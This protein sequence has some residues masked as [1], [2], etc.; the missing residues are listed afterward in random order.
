MVGILFWNVLPDSTPP[1]NSAP[2]VSLPAEVV[3]MVPR[4]LQTAQR[5]FAS[6]PCAARVSAGSPVGETARESR[7]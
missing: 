6:P 3:G 7:G 4:S 5:L 1:Q 2:P